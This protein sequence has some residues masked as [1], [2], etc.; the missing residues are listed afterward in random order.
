L[1]LRAFFNFSLSSS[2][3]EF[4]IKAMKLLHGLYTVTNEITN[5]C[6]LNERHPVLEPTSPRASCEDL[7]LVAILLIRNLL[8]RAP[9]KGKGKKH[10]KCCDSGAI[11]FAMKA[12]QLKIF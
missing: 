4:I 1:S 8:Q 5:L 10:S 11:A 6:P 9:K 12:A 3:P 7:S 2:L